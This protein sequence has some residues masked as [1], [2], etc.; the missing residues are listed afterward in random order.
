MTH[1]GHGGPL[2]SPT[3][4]AMVVLLT[5]SLSVDPDV[6]WSFLRSRRL[7]PVVRVAY[8]FSFGAAS[9]KLQPCRPKLAVRS[10]FPRGAKGIINPG[11]RL[12]LRK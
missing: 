1:L 11:Q 7:A 5:G 8:L 3:H 2:P 4:T 10:S 12:R 6:Q 9:E